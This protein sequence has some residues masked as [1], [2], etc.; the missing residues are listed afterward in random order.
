MSDVI[1]VAD[2]CE[3]QGHRVV[4]LQ[5]RRPELR[6]LLVARGLR[7]VDAHAADPTVVDAS[8]WLDD[9]ISITPRPEPAVRVRE[10]G[11]VLV[12]ASLSTVELMPVVVEVDRVALVCGVDAEA[13]R[14]DIIGDEVAVRSI[15]PWPLADLDRL[16]G[17]RGFELHRR[18]V[19]W[20][21]AAVTADAP[22]HL[23]WFRNI[24]QEP[25]CADVS[26]HR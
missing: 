13:R 2:W 21:G 11:D 6:T 22:C 25:G 20:S 23:S 12:Q 4:A 24:P 15:V 14:V 10:G 3:V 19:D 9:E 1:A 26:S 8:I 16:L 17:E 5:C 7:V 18:S